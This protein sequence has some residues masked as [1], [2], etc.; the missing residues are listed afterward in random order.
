MKF[1]DKKEQVL[2]IQLTQHGKRLLSLGKFKPEFYAFYDDDV[3]YD[4]NY[5][6]FVEDQS[7]TENRILNKTPRLS[8]QYNFSNIEQKKVIKKKLV[9]FTSFIDGKTYSAYEDDEQIEFNTLEMDRDIRMKSIGTSKLNSRYAPAWSV[10]Y[11]NGELDHA[12]ISTTYTGS[13]AGLV[14]RIPQLATE[15]EIEIGVEQYDFPDED[16]DPGGV[17][18]SER[19]NSFV[20]LTEHG[21]DLDD[22]TIR[23]DFFNDGTVLVVK[24]NYILLELKEKNT[25]FLSE[26]FD[27]E[28]FKIGEDDE[29]EKI[30]FQEEFNNV[31]D[32]IL[33]DDKPSTKSSLL[34]PNYVEYFFDFLFD[35]EISV[36]AFC[37]ARNKDKREDPYLD[38]ELFECPDDALPTSD[39]DEAENIYAIPSGP[40]EETC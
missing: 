10:L 36:E 27:V 12:N 26:N 2:D 40:N 14:D 9:N 24:D 37:A 32:G 4:S 13:T 35:G 6:N 39:A 38:E 30:Y 11:L 1:L 19:M 31:K 8:T 18:Q 15:V 22:G 20:S 29:L 3:L 17:P 5:A 23:S 21:N 25:E 16:G 28:V 33:T 34:T 7:E